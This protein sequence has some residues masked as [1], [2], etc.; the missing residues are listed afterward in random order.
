MSRITGSH[1]VLG[2]K[3]L[4]SQLWNC[5]SSVLLGTTG[6]ERSKSWHE[7]VESGEWNHVDRQLPEVSIELTWEPEAGGHS[8]HGQG[9]QMVEVTV[10]G[11]C[12]F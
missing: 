5:E 4:L 2:I 8:G 9:D 6:S 11:G 12:E 10:R 3:H 1:H 7:E